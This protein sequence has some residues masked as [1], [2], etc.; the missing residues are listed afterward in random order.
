MKINVTVFICVCE[1]KY[2]S[3]LGQVMGLGLVYLSPGR[4]EGKLFS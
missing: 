4:D 3:G 1:S 2:D